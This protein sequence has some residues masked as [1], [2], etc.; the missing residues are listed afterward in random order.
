MDYSS[1]VLMLW[2]FLHLGPFLIT[3]T[4]SG[5]QN[6]KLSPIRDRKKQDLQKYQCKTPTSMKFY[7]KK[8]V[9]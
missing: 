5:D 6:I 2:C 1:R 9:L 3:T 4:Q 8:A 7:R